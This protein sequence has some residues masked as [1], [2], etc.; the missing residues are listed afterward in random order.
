MFNLMKKDFIIQK[1]QI[2]FFIPFIIFISIFADLFSPALVFMMAGAYIPING[3]HFD[4]LV[5]SNI[6]LNSLPYTRKEIVAAKYI[7]ALVYMLLSITAA[8]ITLVLFN[9][10]YSIADIAIAVGLSLILIAMVFP[11]FY[12]LNPA[13]LGA[14]IL[15]SLAIMAAIMPSI[16]QYIVHNV[17]EFTDFL[18][19]LSTATIYLSG[20][21]I[22]VSFFM[23]SWLISLY[24]YKNKVF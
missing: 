1:V 20:A 18:S 17:T 21:I 10:N 19:S 5:N 6:L 3:I 12:L 16:I 22:S 15:I 8:G 11:L 2:I 7:G 14:V 9:Y 23:I 13:Y 4:A 24:I